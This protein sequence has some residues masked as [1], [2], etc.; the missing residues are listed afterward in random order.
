MADITLNRSASLL[1]GGA[2]PTR[3]EMPSAEKAQAQNPHYYTDFR[4][5][6]PSWVQ[7]DSLKLFSG[8]MQSLISSSNPADHAIA[9]RI[10]RTDDLQ[11]AV[12]QFDLIMSEIQAKTFTSSSPSAE[13]LQQQM[14][15]LRGRIAEL[16]EDSEMISRYPTG[17]M[18]DARAIR[19]NN[20]Q[21][22]AANRRLQR[23]E[24][25]VEGSSPAAEQ[26]KEPRSDAK[27][28]QARMLARYES[29]GMVD[30]SELPGP[31]DNQHE[32]MRFAASPEIYV[33][34]MWPED[35]RRAYYDHPDRGAANRLALG[36]RPSSA[37][38]ETSPR[39]GESLSRP[40]E[41][42]D[43][44]QRVEQQHEFKMRALERGLR[45]TQD[46]KTRST[47]ERLLE[48]EKSV[49]AANTRLY[50]LSFDP[51]AD[52]AQ[53]TL[54]SEWLDTQKRIKALLK[55]GADIQRAMQTMPR[56]S[57]E[58]SEARA[59]VQDITKE[60]LE[61]SESKVGPDGRIDYRWIPSREKYA[62]NWAAV[63][64][65]YSPK[66]ATPE[67]EVTTSSGSVRASTETAAQISSAQ[68]DQMYRRFQSA[69]RIEAGR[70]HDKA[71]AP[72]RYEIGRL[73]EEQQAELVRSA[74]QRFGTQ[75][76]SAKF[77]E[78]VNSP[79]NEAV[80]IYNEMRK[81]DYAQ[82]NG[83][84]P[85]TIAARKK[86]L[87]ERIESIPEDQRTEVQ[88]L[89]E[90]AMASAAQRQLSGDAVA[91]LSRMRDRLSGTTQ[92]SYV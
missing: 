70:A 66:P 3:S 26:G 62:D 11:G 12:Q 76:D 6:A 19:Q 17:E 85:E 43:E 88:R 50:E 7:S 86:L 60:M 69:Q 35:R 55:D 58:Y 83:S 37:G 18:A 1:N 67:P 47:V 44:R 28:I 73:N 46:P 54:V 78:L 51:S 22:R 30:R 91:A 42:D 38:R 2:D 80:F 34:Y 32:R 41:R 64:G 31:A 79:R 65:R 56:G 36:E 45:E 68:L 9:A 57:T 24:R 27:D 53:I 49:Y 29:L 15:T 20:A 87:A 92:D 89:V 8:Y 77:L 33:T 25:Q 82:E 63:E 90:A 71:L 14:A 10:M 84:N 40:Q 4:S 72:L 48:E 16:Q 59:R 75:S 39:Q 21:I 61:I 13:K 23:L 74:A 81:I 52:R 5:N